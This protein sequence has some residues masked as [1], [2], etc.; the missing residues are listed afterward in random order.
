VASISIDSRSP[1]ST[2]ERRRGVE[3]R[4]RDDGQG[5][6]HHLVGHVELLSVVPPLARA[7]RLLHHHLAVAL[8]ALAVKGRLGEA[9]L[10]LVQLPFAGE[11]ALPED[12]F[13]ALEGEAFHEGGV[14]GDE[15]V[16]HEVG[17]VEEEDRLRADVEAHCVAVIARQADEKFERTVLQRAEVAAGNPVARPGRAFVAS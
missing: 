16:A 9:A 12:D 14:A 6:A 5:E 15:D 2:P 3:Q 1:R 13:R 8:D 4:L 17:T 10:A 11:Q 7:Q